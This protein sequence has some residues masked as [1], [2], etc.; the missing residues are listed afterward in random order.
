ML[1]EALGGHMSFSHV[2]LEIFVVLV[3]F[4]MSGSYKNSASVSSELRDLM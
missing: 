1:L 2:D 4:I 3:S